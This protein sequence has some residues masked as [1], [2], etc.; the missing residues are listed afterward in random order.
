MDLLP[1]IFAAILSPLLTA[2]CKRLRWAREVEAWAAVNLA[3]AVALA[4]FLWVLIDRQ[5]GTLEAWVLQ[6]LAAGGVSGAANN[7]Y[8]KRRARRS[9]RPSLPRLIGRQ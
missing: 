6:G 5:P 8:R 1:V 3:V 7:V 2:G 4:L 9:P